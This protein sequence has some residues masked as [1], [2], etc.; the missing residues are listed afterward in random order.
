M[1]NQ[2]LSVRVG[3][4]FWQP[5]IAGKIRGCDQRSLA[6]GKVNEVTEAIDAKLE[7]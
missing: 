4:L 5:F 6:A 3:G 7:E 1:I 2:M